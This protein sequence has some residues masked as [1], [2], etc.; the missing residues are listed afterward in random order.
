MIVVFVCPF[1]VFPRLL[2]GF[3]DAFALEVCNSEIE[4]SVVPLALC[5]IRSSG[6]PSEAMNGCCVIGRDP[7]SPVIVNAELDKRAIVSQSRR[8]FKPVRGLME[9]SGLA[10]GNGDVDRGAAGVSSTESPFHPNKRLTWI[11]LYTR[12]VAKKNTKMTLRPCKAMFRRTPIPCECFG[13][14]APDEDPSP[15]VLAAVVV[16]YGDQVL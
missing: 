11:F 4:E 3:P 13:S 12:A 8:F 7:F 16:K 10:V 15:P 1:K 5:H 14:R 6:C 9:L 2:E